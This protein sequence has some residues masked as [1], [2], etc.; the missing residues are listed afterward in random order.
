MIETKVKKPKVPIDWGKIKK[1]LL[2]HKRL[3]Y[4]V[5]AIAFVLSAIY[6]L[7][8]P[9]YYICTV[10]L[11]PEMS[12]R[13]SSMS[14]ISSLASRFGVKIGSNTDY[15]EA[16][17]PTLYPDIISSVDYKASLLDVKVR[18]RRSDEEYTYY[19]YL[20]KIRKG[21]WWGSVIGSFFSLFASKDSIKE[22]Q[23]INPRRLTKRQTSLFNSLN[24]LVACKVDKKTMVI[25]ISVK[26]NDPEV[27]TMVADSAVALLQRAVTDYRTS[28]ARVDLEHYRKMHKEAKDRYVR[29]SQ[30]YARFADSNMQTFREST[31]QRQTELEVEMQLQRTIYQ[32]VSAQ[33]EQAEM[34]VLEATPAFAVI[35]G[36]TVPA[37]KSGPQRK[38]ICLVFLAL[39]FIGITCYILYK[40]HDIRPLL[41]FQ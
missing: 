8:L 18:P 2:K 10:E 36:S 35:Q 29:A 15:T 40:E 37:R 19:D 31:R 7:S 9:N 3:Y 26:D 39:A 38:K 22:P 16:L 34:K 21:P 5:L 13:S 1:D 32:Q 14:N 33:L 27:C 28:K 25:T 17:F 11:S 12:G 41:G 24:G 4:I 23:T 20:T 30:A 6:T